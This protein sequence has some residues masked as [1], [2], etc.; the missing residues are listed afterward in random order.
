MEPIIC[1]VYKEHMSTKGSFLTNI[2]PITNS[3]DNILIY[4]FSNLSGV[5]GWY[6]EDT[7]CYFAPNFIVLGLSREI[8]VNTNK[9]YF[10]I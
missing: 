8:P 1:F 3:A 10:G 6:L 9:I 5:I 2:A 4:F 7:F